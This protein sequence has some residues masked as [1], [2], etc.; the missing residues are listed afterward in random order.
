MQV[1]DSL[2]AVDVAGVLVLRYP[3]PL[4]IGRHV[5]RDCVPGRVAITAVHNRIRPVGV[6]KIIR[7]PCWNQTTLFDRKISQITIG[8]ASDCFRD[9]KKPGHHKS[10]ITSDYNYQRVDKH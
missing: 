8:V 7:L 6:V 10:R 5:T 3:D 1:T 9:I 2:P 4:G